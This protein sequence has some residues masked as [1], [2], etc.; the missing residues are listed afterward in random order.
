MKSNLESLRVAMV[1]RD[2]VIRGVG[3]TLGS[4]IIT[5]GENGVCF[6]DPENMTQ[7]L[8]FSVEEWNVIVE[9][10]DTQ[11]L[12]SVEP[13]AFEPDWESVPSNFNYYGIDSSGQGCYF[14]SK[15]Q[16]GIYNDEWYGGGEYLL[17]KVHAVRPADWTQTL[18]MRSGV[19][20]NAAE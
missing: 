2:V 7:G 19:T 4:I 12:G 8:K 5:A 16:L 13:Q 14:E 10:V 1:A 17:H 15:P 18:V 11:L 3:R 9:F 20:A 6:T